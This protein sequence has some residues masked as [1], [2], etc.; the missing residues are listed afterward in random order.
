M[1][2]RGEVW[3]Y[4]PVIPRPGI[5]TLRLIVSADALNTAE[6]LNHVLAVHILDQDLE[7]ELLAPRIGEHGWAL[8]T[9]V[10]R[11][12]RSRLIEKIGEATPAEIAQVTN[13]LRVALA[14]DPPP[15]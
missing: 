3:A 14:L 1:I 10:E 12:V 13:G 15:A 9:T 7:S 8:V 6:H 2:R 4:K 5:S 11:V